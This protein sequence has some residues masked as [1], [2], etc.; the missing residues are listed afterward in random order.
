MTKDIP[1][2]NNSPNI[3]FMLNFIW[4]SFRSA[5]WLKLLKWSCCLLMYYLQHCWE[6][7][8]PFHPPRTI[9]LNLWGFKFVLHQTETSEKMQ[10]FLRCGGR[11]KMQKKKKKQATFTAHSSLLSSFFLALQDTRREGRSSPAQRRLSPAPDGQHW[12]F[13]SPP[14]LPGSASSSLQTRTRVL[15]GKSGMKVEQSLDLHN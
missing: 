14:W 6:Q 11:I 8:N 10:V 15:T 4:I 1:F 3:P 9:F 13:P 2:R 7:W 5:I 12:S